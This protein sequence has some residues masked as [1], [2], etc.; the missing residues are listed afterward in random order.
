M[1]QEQKQHI[2]Q[3]FAQIQPIAASVASL[4]YGRLFAIAPQLQPLFGYEIGSTEMVQQGNKLM[5][6]L[7]IAVANLDQIEHVLP[8]LEALARRH[9]AYGVEPDHYDLV[10]AALLWTLEQALGDGY[11][12]E[13]AAAWQALYTTIATTMKR[14]A[15][16]P[17][18]M[19]V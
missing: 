2:R 9:V 4:F 7:T 10:G 19:V 17:Q 11:T 14:A 8:A 15:Y 1:N 16:S 6:M 13:C 5:H 3:T 12:A 18:A